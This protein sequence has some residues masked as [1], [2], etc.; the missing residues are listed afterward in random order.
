MLYLV[1]FIIQKW[2]ER[3][4]RT[5]AVTSFVASCYQTQGPSTRRTQWLEEKMNWTLWRRWQRRGCWLVGTQNSISD[6]LPSLLVAIKLLNSAPLFGTI[7]ISG[8]QGCWGLAGH[9]VWTYNSILQSLRTRAIHLFNFVNTSILYNILQVAQLYVCTCL[10]GH[11]FFTFALVFVFAQFFVLCSMFVYHCC[12]VFF[13]MHTR[14]VSFCSTFPWSGLFSR[15]SVHQVSWRLAWFCLADDVWWLTKPQLHNKH[16]CVK[17]NG[18]QLNSATLSWIIRIVCH[19]RWSAADPS[20]L[21][22]ADRSWSCCSQQTSSE[23]HINEAA[24]WA[25][26]MY[27]FRITWTVYKALLWERISLKWSVVC[28]PSDSAIA[29]KAKICCWSDRRRH[30]ENLSLGSSP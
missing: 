14:V 10:N 5:G 26:S 21:L 13:S 4:L 3:R 12:G 9:A 17:K 24:H 15:Y 23:M 25:L 18:M 8:L 30:I 7:N 11:I 1:C 27:P 29:A 16:E 2:N 6:S 28:S 22:F 20:S 19:E